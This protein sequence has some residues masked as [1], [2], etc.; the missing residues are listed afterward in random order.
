[1]GARQQ[2]EPA[3]PTLIEGLKHHARAVAD[4]VDLADEAVRRGRRRAERSAPE[5]AVRH[6]S[7]SDPRSRYCAVLG[8][9][10]VAP[11]PKVSAGP[12]IHHSAFEPLPGV[13]AP[14]TVMVPRGP[15]PIPMA[16]RSAEEE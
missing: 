1:M 7:R 4:A 13:R 9:A 6:L 16:A 8:D 3:I 2:L 14:F 12:A 11:A 10:S 15:E 5:K